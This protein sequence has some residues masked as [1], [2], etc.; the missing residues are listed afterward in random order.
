[1]GYRTY[2]SLQVKG[3]TTEQ[4]YEKL[5][6]EMKSMD[7]FGYAFCSPCKFNNY[8]DTQH[9]DSFDS[10]KWYD[11]DEDMLHLSSKFPEMT[12]MLHGEGEES[13]D[14][15]NTYYYDGTAEECKANIE[16][17]KPKA[18]AW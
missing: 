5:C 4:K 15:W 18:I 14:L 10:V 12:F 1:M 6:G 16:Y 8:E 17:P 13:E 11:Y 9:F 7:L 2:Y 3:C